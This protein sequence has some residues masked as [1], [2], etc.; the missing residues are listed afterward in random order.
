MLEA[1]DF[2]GAC[3]R[4]ALSPP[5]LWTLY[6]PYFEKMFQSLI[7]ILREAF[8]IAICSGVMIGVA[9]LYV[10][11]QFLR[12]TFPRAK[13]RRQIFLTGRNPGRRIGRKIG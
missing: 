5:K 11:K 6:F 7:E 12:L 8:G 2:L 10:R 3:H 13:L 1:D 4:K 9:L